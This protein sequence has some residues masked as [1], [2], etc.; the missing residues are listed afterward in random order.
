[1]PAHEQPANRYARGR[2]PR[3]PQRPDRDAVAPHVRSLSPTLPNLQRSLG[4]TAVARLHAAVHR[5]AAPAPQLAASVCRYA[6]DNVL[7][8]PAQPLAAPLKEEMAARLGGDFARVPVH[9]DSTARGRATEAGGRT[10]GPD[11]VIGP[12]TPDTRTLAHELNPVIQQHQ[13]PVAGIQLLSDADRRPDT[14]VDS[15]ALR[16]AISSG[17]LPLEASVR[18]DMES[19]FAADFSSVRVHTGVDAARSARAVAAAA[20]TTG[21][22]IVL[23][24]Q[25]AGLATG[26]GRGILAHE[27]AHVVQQRAGP[28][29]GIPVGD[30]MTVSDPQDRFERAADNVARAALAGG[31]AHPGREARSPRGDLTQTADAVQHFPGPGRATHVQRKVGF[32]FEAQWNVRRVTGSEEEKAAHRTAQEEYWD[33]VYAGVLGGIPTHP[34]SGLSGVPEGEETSEEA[35]QREKW[36]DTDG[37]KHVINDVGRDRAKKWGEANPEL[38]RERAALMTKD[39]GEEPLEGRNLGKGDKVVKATDY[40][41]E[42]DT[43]PTGG[44]NLEWVTKALDT[45]TQV[46]TV[47]KSLTAMARFLNTQMGKEYILSEDVTA[48]G[49]TPERG[50][51]IYPYRGAL[52][53]APQTTGGFRIDQLPALLDYLTEFTPTHSASKVPMVPFTGAWLKQSQSRA[54]T[55]LF[56]TPGNMQDA[57]IGAR[58]AV[59]TAL[60]ESQAGEPGARTDLK[61]IVAREPGAR[62]G[63]EG[64]VALLAN[65]LITG[66]RQFEGA[67]AK[68]IAGALMA[69]TDFAH[70]FN[71]L[72]AG[73]AEPYRKQPEA[74]V[75]LVLDAAR[76]GGMTGSEGDRVFRHEVERYEAGNPTPT[77]TTIPLT[78]QDWLHNIPLG[79]DKLK[80]PTLLPATEETA[81]GM[82]GIHKSLGALGTVEDQVG[83]EKEKM[84]AVVVEFR[85]M[86]DYLT[87]DELLPL[88]VAVFDLIEQVNAGRKYSSEPTLLETLGGKNLRYRR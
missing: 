39:I 14:P 32:E 70:N 15:A 23:G 78:R 64:L 65:Y 10:F 12:G 83:P 26:T 46:Q 9:T 76:R 25:V 57:L 62:T 11:V 41:L 19:R 33:K 1:M 43:S 87:V 58:N 85:R 71:Q 52:E 59:E 45:R 35:D 50:L 2:T 40:D 21:E 63:L 3:P 31:A 24:E 27:L 54:R 53:F 38:L 77:K 34:Q 60:K 66:D 51:R 44:S 68:S 30:D 28:V 61:G 6:A 74:F 56:R 49:G 4:S 80:H 84:K 17:G 73:L 79:T 36:F 5:T 7:D 81:A 55:D 29:G 22:H 18:A 82:E 42:A 47:M 67:N 86:R 75:A 20:Y 13:G 37:D 69:R 48:G 72:N 88:A 16:A 8:S